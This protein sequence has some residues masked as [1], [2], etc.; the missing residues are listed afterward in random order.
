MSFDDDSGV[1][2]G[3]INPDILQY[4]LYSISYFYME[5]QLERNI[6]KCKIIHRGV[7]NHKLI[8]YYA[9]QVTHQLAAKTKYLG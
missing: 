1:E 9:G 6:N 2:R 5:L 7:S 4:T 8:I 3:A